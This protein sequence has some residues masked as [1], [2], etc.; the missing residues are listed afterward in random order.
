MIYDIGNTHIHSYVPDVAD[1]RQKAVIQ[2][3]EPVNS[4]DDQFMQC[5]DQQVCM[6]AIKEGQI[7]W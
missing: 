1:N 6:S 3:R 4:R 2:S 7:D 5:D